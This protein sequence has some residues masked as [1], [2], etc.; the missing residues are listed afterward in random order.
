LFFDEIPD[1]LDRRKT[2][3]FLGGKDIIIDASVSLSL[4]SIPSLGLTT[5]I[6]RTR[7]YLE[8]RKCGAY[9]APIAA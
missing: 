2:A 6:Q 5:D 1:G 3:F 9:R 8:D 7:K 4:L